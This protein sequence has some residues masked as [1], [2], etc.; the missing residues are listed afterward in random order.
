MM[1]KAMES[2]EWAS[3]IPTTVSLSTNRQLRL[4]PELSAETEDHVI[5]NE[6]ISSG[7]LSAMKMPGPAASFCANH[8]SQ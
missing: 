7:R 2:L 3:F 8:L 6:D 1:V 5:K 4:L